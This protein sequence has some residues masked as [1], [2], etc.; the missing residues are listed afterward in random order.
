M[1][2][3]GRDKS[4]YPLSAFSIE[5]GVYTREGGEVQTESEKKQKEKN[6]QVFGDVMFFNKNGATI[7]A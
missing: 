4:L 7:R 6:E 3:G 5:C 1:R 2:G